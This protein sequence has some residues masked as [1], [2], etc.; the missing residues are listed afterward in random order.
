MRHGFNS[1]AN[2]IFFKIEACL[3]FLERKNKPRLINEA[4][5]YPLLKYTVDPL[6]VDPPQ[7]R[8]PPLNGR[9]RKHRL[10]LAC[11]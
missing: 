4:G 3:Y 6:I 10:I 9:D 7:S 1:G 5:F 2:F 8:Q 11:I